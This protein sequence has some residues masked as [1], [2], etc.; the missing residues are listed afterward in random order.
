M[1][2]KVEFRLVIV[3]LGIFLYQFFKDTTLVLEVIV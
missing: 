1:Y 3:R 2:G